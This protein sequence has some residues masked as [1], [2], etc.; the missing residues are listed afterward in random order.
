LR[1]EHRR[2]IPLVLDPAMSSQNQ[3]RAALTGGKQVRALVAI[4]PTARRLRTRTVRGRAPKWLGSPRTLPARCA[5]GG[6]RQTVRPGFLGAV[7]AKPCRARLR[8]P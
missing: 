8:G 6:G 1:R 5:V 3:C 7:K 2:A 4:L